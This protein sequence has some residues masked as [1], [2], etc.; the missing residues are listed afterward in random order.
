MENP[1]LLV[2]V[3]ILPWLLSVIDIMQVGVIKFMVPLFLLKEIIS[4]IPEKNQW[5]F[6]HKLF[7]GISPF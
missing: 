7:L 4:V 2:R 5:V 1:Y 6:V 3:L